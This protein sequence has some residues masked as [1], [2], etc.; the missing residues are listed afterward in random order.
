MK[1]AIILIVHFLLVL[2]AVSFASVSEL[3]QQANAYYAQ[4]H[5]DSAAAYY[6]QVIM[7][8]PQDPHVY[9]NLGNAYYR[10]NNI[11]MAVLNYQ[12]ALR[13][14]PDYKAASENLLLAEARISNHI[15]NGQ[16]LFFVQWWKSLTRPSNT[17][18][19]GVIGIVCFLLML[20][21]ILLRYYRD[22][23]WV[24]PQLIVGLGVGCALFLLFAFVAAGNGQLRDHA[25]VM[26]SDAP[27]VAAPQQTKGQS[28]IPEGTTVKIL[29]KKAGYAEIRLPDGRSG[30][31]SQ[32][33]L[34]EI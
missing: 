32:T 14:D 30:W 13:L 6:E 24:R 33:Y 29:N 12:R 21:A 9:Y 16:D 22:K 27:L 15:Q 1:R 18:T 31:M 5:Y 17:N 8:R 11:G 10:L 25:I 2:P 23:E 20:S 19:L 7:Q 34:E 3:W 28:Y 4:Q 26:H